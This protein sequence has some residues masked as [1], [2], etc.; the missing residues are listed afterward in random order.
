MLPPSVLVGQKPNCGAPISF[1]VRTD[2]G[3][4]VKELKNIAIKALVL[5]SLYLFNGIFAAPSVV[6]SI[7]KLLLVQL[8]FSTRTSHLM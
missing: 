5:S 1:E 3:S 7:L 8:L 2:S 6:N 4:A